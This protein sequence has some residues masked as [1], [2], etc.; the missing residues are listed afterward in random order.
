MVDI[1]LGRF[2]R[3]QLILEEI[4]TA[5]AADPGTEE[6]PVIGSDYYGMVRIF[7]TLGGTVSDADLDVWVQEG[8]DWFLLE[9]VELDPAADSQAVDVLVGVDTRFGI[10]VSTLSGSGAEV[11]VSVR[12]V[13]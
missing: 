6:L 4:D 10:T 12:G 3:A 11:S 2:S 8:E 13:A 7:A 9:T 5:H 1:G